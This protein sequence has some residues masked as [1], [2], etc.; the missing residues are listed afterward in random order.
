MHDLQFLTNAD[1]A[2]RLS[3]PQLIEA[4]R[5]GLAGPCEAP[6]RGCHEL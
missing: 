1:V 6:V 3:Y 4:L 2:A 5:I